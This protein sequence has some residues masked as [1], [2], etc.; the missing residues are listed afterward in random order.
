[1]FMGRKS[2]YFY[3]LRGYIPHLAARLE[4]KQKQVP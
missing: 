2:R 3:V 1:M 4:H